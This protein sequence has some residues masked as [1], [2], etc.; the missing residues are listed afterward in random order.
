MTLDIARWLQQGAGRVDG[1][2]DVDRL[3]R[4]ARRLRLRRRA[5][6]VTAALLAVALVPVG[7]AGVRQL[8]A[9]PVQAPTVT[10]QS[11][12]TSAGTASTRP[13]QVTVPDVTRRPLD[14]ARRLLT[15]AGL[16]AAVNHGDPTGPGSVVV[17]QEPPGGSVVPA[18]STIGLR[19]AVVTP[20]LCATLAGVPDVDTGFFPP[21]PR[22]LARLDAVAKV[23]PQT[24]RSAVQTVAAYL[25]AHPAATRG[26]ATAW[27][28]PGAGP[29]PHPPPC[30]LTCASHYLR[31]RRAA[32]RERRGQRL[33]ARVCQRHGKLPC[34]GEG[35]PVDLAS[36]RK[37]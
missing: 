24:L 12:A 6:V 35:S 10:S 23:A 13:R 4:R 16:V 8:R 30:L 27:G 33:L 11:P 26:E 15:T 3:R 25:R 2:L 37:R 18:R 36:T 31:G 19:L 29:P 14:Q 7:L 20:A 9:P 34:R 22:L 1:E 21:S 5:A 32:D 28:R 17:A